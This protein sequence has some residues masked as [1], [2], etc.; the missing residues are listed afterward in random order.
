MMEIH[1]I[2]KLNKGSKVV[3]ISHSCIQYSLLPTV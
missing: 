1:L 2:V 3:D